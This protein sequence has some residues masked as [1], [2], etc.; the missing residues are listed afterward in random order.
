MTVE[1]SLSG[2]TCSWLCFPCPAGQELI[3]QKRTDIRWQ[4]LS[5]K[6]DLK[7]VTKPGPV[8]LG[9]V[10]SVYVHN[11]SFFFLEALSPPKRTM[12]MSHVFWEVMQ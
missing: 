9:Q 1:V 5:L 8:L 11:D 2:T 10:H 4:V 3:G 12:S 7:A 6:H